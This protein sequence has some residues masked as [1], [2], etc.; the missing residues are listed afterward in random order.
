MRFQINQWKPKLFMPSHTD[1]NIISIHI[2][3]VA[4]YL[5]LYHVIGVVAECPTADRIRTYAVVQGIFNL[6]YLTS[7]G[8][9][10]YYA[11]SKDED[12]CLCYSMCCN[13][14]M[15]VLLIVWT[16]IGTT[17]VWRTLEE[18]KDDNSTC[19]GALIIST[20]VC[21]SLHYVVVLLFCCLCC[22]ICVRICN[23][24]SD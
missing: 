14:L 7:Y 18:W 11:Y 4:S 13:F 6:V 3:Y 2:N 5:M 17:W 23:D 9:S 10:A 22:G 24:K 20:A 16:L 21:L 12:N 19:S 8:C 1:M 15:A